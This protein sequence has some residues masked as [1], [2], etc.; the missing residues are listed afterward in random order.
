MQHRF[1]HPI[2][3]NA[4][5]DLIKGMIIES[6]LVKIRVDTLEFYQKKESIFVSLKSVGS[7]MDFTVFVISIRANKYLDDE[8]SDDIPI[9]LRIIP[10]DD[11]YALKTQK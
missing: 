7:F 1:L 11:F 10:P 6:H 5:V 8:I 4:I 2:L 3:C 9:E